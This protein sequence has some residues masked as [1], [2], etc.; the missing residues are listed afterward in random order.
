MQRRALLVAMAEVELL[1][2]PALLADERIVLRHAAVVV[3]P[4]DRAVVV[5]W[6]LRP[7]HL[8]ALAERQVEEAG[9]VEDDAAAEVQAAG[10]L[11]LLPE[12]H[13]QVLAPA[14]AKLR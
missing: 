5:A 14:R 7:L 6:H 12:D 9:A 2:P 13:L 4:D 1:R 10:S 11:R 8:A 3:Q